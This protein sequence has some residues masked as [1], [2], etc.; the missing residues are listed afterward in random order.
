MEE[1]LDLQAFL[2][3]FYAA[4]CAPSSAHKLSGVCHDLYL[5]DEETEGQAGTLTA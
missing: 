2:G 1:K 4:A 3:E 5:T